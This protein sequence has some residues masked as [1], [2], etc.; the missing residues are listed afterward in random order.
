MKRPILRFRSARLVCTTLLACVMLL[1]CG[2]T[3]LAAEE[4][5]PDLV[6][7]TTPPLINVPLPPYPEDMTEAE[8]YPADVQSIFEG[9]TRQIVKTYILT[10]EQSPADIPR[11]GFIRDGWWYELTDITEQRTIGTDTRSFTETVEISTDTKD[12]N[13]IIKLLSPTLDYQGEDGYCGLLTLDR[14]C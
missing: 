9:G 8:L 14:R 11:D 12:L 10:V 1:F 13:E 3:A 4:G 7:A 5:S 2:L 6:Q